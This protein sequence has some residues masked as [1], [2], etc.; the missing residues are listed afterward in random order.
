MISQLETDMHSDEQDL[1]ALETLVVDNPD[2][3]R[4]EELLSPFNIFEAIGAVR[5]EVRHSD[6]LAFLLNPQQNHGIGDFF[7]TRF[8]QRAIRAANKSDIHV[9]PI[10]LDLWSLD[11]MM[12]IREW[13]GID[14][15]LIDESCQLVVVIENKVDS[16]EHDDQLARYWDTIEKRYSG[17]CKI[18]LFLS[19]DKRSPSDDRF[20]PIDYEMICS[21]VEGIIE[22]RS[23]TLGTDI[24]LLLSH[25]AQMLRRHIVSN[26]E[27]AELCRRIYQKHQRALDAIYEYRPD[28]QAAIRDI[29]ETIINDT[30]SLVL[31]R[32]T[33]S[34][35]NFAI[36]EIDTPFLAIAS[37]WTSSN[38]ILLFAFAN[39]PTSLQLKLIIGPGPSEIRQRLFDLASEF[40]PPFKQTQKKLRTKWNTI[41]TKSILSIQSYEKSM[42]EIEQEIR[43]HWHQFVTSDLPAMMVVLRKQQ[44]IF[45]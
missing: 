26:S 24:R 44:W 2:F 37:D 16:L 13:Q 39:T 27:L 6:F 14:I 34:E 32:C 20:I 3:E 40:Q 5:Q 10:D 12:V 28:P 23:N 36:R 1:K 4:L 11:E 18:G 17:W 31:D 25:Y 33:K 43:Q 41:Y 29:L 35:V 21:L 45:G 38:R 22:G 42:D 15:L 8:L 7:V 9:T 19:P 30:D